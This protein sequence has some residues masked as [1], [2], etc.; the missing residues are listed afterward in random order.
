M[1]VYTL[2]NERFTL[3]ESCY[4]K[5]RVFHCLQKKS[6]VD[7]PSNSLEFGIAECRTVTESYLLTNTATLGESSRAP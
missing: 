7:S 1:G 2:K 4:H 3:I 5:L 6:S